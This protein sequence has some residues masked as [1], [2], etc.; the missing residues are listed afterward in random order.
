M[1]EKE[2]DILAAMGVKSNPDSVPVSAANSKFCSTCG[3]Q[4]NVKAEMC[5][6]CGAVL[7]TNKAYTVQNISTKASNVVGVYGIVFGIAASAM[8]FIAGLVCFSG[9][10]MGGLGNLPAALGL[11][12]IAKSLF[13]GPMIILASRK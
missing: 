10:Y 12:F 2:N 11:Y 8:S 1:S 7:T 6:H 13:M 5:P 4:I 9:E 3:K